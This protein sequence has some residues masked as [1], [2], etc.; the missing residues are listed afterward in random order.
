MSEESII[1]CDTCGNVLGER[2]FSFAHNVERIEVT[3]SDEALHNTFHK[4]SRTVLRAYCGASCWGMGEVLQA[5]TL[6]LATVYPAF[7]LATPCSRCSNLVDRTRTHIN[8]S[9]SEFEVDFKSWNGRCIE[10]RDFAILCRSCEAPDSVGQVVE[11]FAI[12]RTS[13]NVNDE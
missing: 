1:H 3:G 10:E 2:H 12:E 8:Y 11:D 5:A 9:I 7:S 4:Q 6:Q 13:M